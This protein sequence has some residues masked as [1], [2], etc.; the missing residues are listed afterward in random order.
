MGWYTFS[1]S[2]LV[3]GPLVADHLRDVATDPLALAVVTS[4]TQVYCRVLDNGE[5]FYFSP[6][7]CRVFKPFL[8]TYGAIPCEPPFTGS[9][10]PPGLSRLDLQ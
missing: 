7:A 1:V 2:P 9:A 10:L 3:Y 5:Q 4:D 6:T 8:D